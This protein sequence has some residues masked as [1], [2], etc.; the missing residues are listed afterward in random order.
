MQTIVKRFGEIGADVEI[1]EVAHPFWRGGGRSDFAIDVHS[2]RRGEYFDLL[3]ASNVGLDVLDARPKDRHLL[4]LVR[5][6]GMSRFL[7]GHD[8]RHWFVAAIREP[9]STVAAAKEAL[10][11]PLVRERQQR[12]R[13]KHRNRRRNRAYLRQ[14]E[15]FFVPASSSDIEGGFV[16]RDQPLA[17]A[18]GKPHMADEVVREGG[19]TRFARGRITHPDHRTVVLDGWH[20]V[21]ASTEDRAAVARHVA[22]AD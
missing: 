2:D 17:A 1:R 12:V 6:A 4:L 14:G 10:K 16:L 13:A 9:V 21:L 22:F 7:C 5:G 18:R 8:E 19:E 15:W 11:P 20:R 3:V